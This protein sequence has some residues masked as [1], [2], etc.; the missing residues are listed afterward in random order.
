LVI[1]LR[2]QDHQRAKIM[3]VSWAAT[4]TTKQGISNRAL[5]G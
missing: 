1:I 2:L 5:D 3:T 4:K